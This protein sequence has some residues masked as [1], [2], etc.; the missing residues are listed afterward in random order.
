[1]PAG[2]EPWLEGFGLG[3][4]GLDLKDPAP[5]HGPL[6]ARPGER[7]ADADLQIAAT[8]IYHDLELVTGNV[9]HFARVPGLRLHP[10]LAAA[11]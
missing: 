2:A 3:R 8:A 10:A 11:R 9:R 1:M 4:F 7:L 5:S 6:L